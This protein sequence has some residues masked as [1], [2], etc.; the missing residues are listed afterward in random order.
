MIKNL[1]NQVL[2]LKG[3]VRV[4]CRIRPVLECDH[5]KATAKMTKNYQVTSF[6]SKERVNK[7]MN[8]RPY[9]VSDTFEFKGEKTVQ[10]MIDQP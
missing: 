6:K 4:F 5:A 9:E 3:N 10:V 7:L 1:S 2:E 8:G